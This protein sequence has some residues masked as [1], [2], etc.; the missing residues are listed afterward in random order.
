[1][2][3][4]H[5]VTIAVDAVG[6]DF[7][8]K[9]VLDGI[10]LALGQD[11]GLTVL[12]TGPAHVVEPFA[13]QHAA[14]VTAVPTS[15]II[16]MGEHPATAVRSKKDSSIVV[17]CRLVR[18]GAAQ[19]FF[20]AG[21]TGAAMAAATLV[22]GRIKGVSRPAIATVLPTAGVPAVML[23]V[24]ANADCKPENLLQFAHMGAAYAAVVLDMVHPRVA[25]LNIGEEPSKGSILAQEAHTLLAQQM[26][27]FVGNIEGREV[28]AGRTDVIVTDGFTGNVALK[29]LEGTSSVLMHQ[30]KDA[31]T[32]S[33]VNKLAAAVVAPSLRRMAA[34]LDPDEY[35][36]AP[37]LGVNGVCI[38]GHGSSSATAVSNALRVAVSA[39][40]GG[41]TERIA[42]ALA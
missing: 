19:G 38:I 39:V 12:L 27:G 5:P 16:E 26:P 10:I 22:M 20:S 1:M 36:G 11:D 37:L 35:G 15:E 23:D 24:G 42:Q 34:R 4:S 6:G 30:V 18:D 33:V 31:M 13:R 17:G 25:L 28:L 7:A 3:A 41:L 8:P 32:S 9:A 21:S 29:L 14:R 2:S 40:R